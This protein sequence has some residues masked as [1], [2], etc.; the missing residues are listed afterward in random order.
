MLRTN[1]PLKVIR[2]YRVGLW[3]RT[4]SPLLF[5]PQQECYL[6]ERFGAY[7]FVFYKF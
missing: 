4:I 3:K 7:R 1:R 6:I 2:N 5:V